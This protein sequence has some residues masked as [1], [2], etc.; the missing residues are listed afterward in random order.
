ML[1]FR[2]VR[3]RGRRDSHLSGNGCD[4]AFLSDKSASSELSGRIVHGPRGQVGHVAVMCPWGRGGQRPPGPVSR[5]VASRSRGRSF[6]SGRHCWGY[7]WSDVCSFGYKKDTDKLERGQ[8][9][10][11]EVADGYSTP[12]ARRGW[13][14]RWVGEELTTAHSCLRGSVGGGRA[15]AALRAAP[16]RLRSSTWEMPPRYK[17]LFPHGSEHQRVQRGHGLSILRYPQ[18]DCAHPWATCAACFEQGVGLETSSGPFWTKLSCHS[19]EKLWVFWK[20]PLQPHFSLF[21]FSGVKS[22]WVAHI[23]LKSAFSSLS[24][25]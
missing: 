3:L 9:G 15:Q 12:H 21:F 4:L 5:S 1:F 16:G 13:G 6:P 20:A 22:A 24:F 11:Y 17:V 19:T 25:C 14:K 2:G 8:W 23:Y 7:V 10:V 18:R